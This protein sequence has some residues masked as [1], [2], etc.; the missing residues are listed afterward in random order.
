MSARL[1]VLLR[2][3]YNVGFLMFALEKHLPAAGG[4]GGG[5][6]DAAAAIRLLEALWGV[7]L[8]DDRRMALALDLG[9]DVPACL[10]GQACFVGGIGEAL[11]PAPPLPPAGLVLVNPGVALATP[12]VFAAR[13][14][15]FSEPGRFDDAPADAAALAALLARRRNDLTAAALE[16]APAVGAV[17]A[18]L[19]S[20][21][22]VLLAR[23]SGSG[24]TCF[25]LC[26]DADA[27]RTAAGR[28]AGA[29]PDWWVRAARLVGDARHLEP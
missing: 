25:G 28:I 9:A 8:A 3:V 6:G 27:A 19:E 4:I 23:M 5:S 14:A 11:A 7:A 10:A 2:L 12:R 17:L 24:A 16:L 20:C 29:R 13:T 21:D 1:V 26:R 22:E 15:P 18:M